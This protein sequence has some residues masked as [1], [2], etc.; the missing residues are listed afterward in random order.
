[1]DS[2]PNI[3]KTRG[4]K[5][6]KNN[7]TFFIKSAKGKEGIMLGEKVDETQFNVTLNKNDKS[8]IKKGSAIKGSHLEELSHKNDMEDILDMSKEENTKFYEKGS[9]ILVVSH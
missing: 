6:S 2:L 7:S 3:F 8:N 5:N 9:V 1:M 4:L